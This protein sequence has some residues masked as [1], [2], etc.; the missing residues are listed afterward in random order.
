MGSKAGFS[1]LWLFG[2]REVQFFILLLLFFL[3]FFIFQYGGIV[4]TCIKVGVKFIE[5]FTDII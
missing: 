3:F 1:S 2:S 4:N 5:M